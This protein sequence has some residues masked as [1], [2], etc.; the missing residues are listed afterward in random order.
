MVDD[1]SLVVEEVVALDTVEV[2]RPE[3]A[4]MSSSSGDGSDS[5]SDEG[6]ET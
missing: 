3:E 5:R 2:V 1:R 6:I 4:V